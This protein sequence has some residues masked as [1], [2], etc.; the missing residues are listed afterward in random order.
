[1]IIF[2]ISLVVFCHAT[3]DERKPWREGK[4]FLNSTNYN[5]Y[6]KSYY[7]KKSQIT[8]R[9]LGVGASTTRYWDCDQPFCE[10]GRIPYPHPYRPYRMSDGRI[11]AHA[12]AS[13]VILNGHAACEKCYELTYHGNVNIFVVK[14]DNWCSCDTNEHRVCCEPHFDIAVPGTDWQPASR[15]NVCTQTDTSILYDKGRQACSHWPWEDGLECCGGVSTDEQLNQACRL[16][17]ST[18]W[19]NPQVTYAE[20]SCPY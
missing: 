18:G 19:N 1:M 6:L 11:F 15:S 8:R 7:Q 14:V 12:A 13:D 16:F 2:I 4:T 3:H 10:P 9:S 5:N 17:V 20:V